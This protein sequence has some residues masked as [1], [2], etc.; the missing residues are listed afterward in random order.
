MIWENLVSQKVIVKV[1]PNGPNCKYLLTYLINGFIIQIS[2][3]LSFNFF[4]KVLHLL[5][6]TYISNPDTV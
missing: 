6:D 3:T 4:F 1:H 2:G 5:S